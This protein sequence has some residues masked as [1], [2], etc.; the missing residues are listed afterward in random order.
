MDVWLHGPEFLRTLPVKWPKVNLGSLA[1]DNHTISM[2]VI[3]HENSELLDLGR[4]SS[5][6]KLYRVAYLVLK[7][8]KLI[9]KKGVNEYEIKNEAKLLLI[10]GEQIKYFSNEISFL[11][12]DSKEL[13]RRV[14]YLNLFL[15]VNRVLRSKG[16]IDKCEVY[17]YD[18]KHPILLHKYSQLTKLV[19]YDS[20]VFCKHLGV[21]ST[22]S[23][24]RLAGFW[25]PQARSTVK[26]VLINCIIC[27]KINGLPFQYPKQIIFVIKLI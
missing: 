8:T 14:K 13:P 10:R 7:F 17:N 5:V 12:G 21:G 20:H 16:R 15:D 4:F 18:Q 26:N 24:V 11:R 3:V 2:N 9:A 23:A 1:T 6:Q 27:K 22:L 25:I 19:V